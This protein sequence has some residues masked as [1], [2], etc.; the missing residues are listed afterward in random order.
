MAHERRDSD[1]INASLGEK[2]IVDIIYVKP[3]ENFGEAGHLQV[4]SKYH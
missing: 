2:I 1:D 4:E 3:Q